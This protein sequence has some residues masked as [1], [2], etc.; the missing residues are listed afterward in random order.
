MELSDLKKIGLTQGE[1]KIY[2]A[3]LELGESTRTEIAKKSGISPSKV[4][5]VANRLIEKGIISSVKKQGITHFNAANPERLKDYL[6][7]K[8]EEISH[9][10]NIVE[11]LLPSLLL[12]YNQTKEETQIEVFYGW[13]G[14]KTA[15]NDITRTLNKQDENYVLGASTGQN[16]KQADLFF[17]QYYKKVEKKGY[18]IKIIFNENLRENNKRTNYFTQSKKH[19]TKF[20][21]QNTFTELNLY[22]DTVLVTLLLQKPII[23]KI[24]S[25]EATDSFKKYFNTLWK[26][27]AV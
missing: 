19:E 24:Q 18:K 22:K 8:K 11:K 9:E 13:E 16:T 15:F 27:A 17:T 26:N 14:M 1:L 2:N 6:Q 10:Q 23:I 12:K 20:L 5:D 25:K 4:Y 21:H 3:L 7:Q